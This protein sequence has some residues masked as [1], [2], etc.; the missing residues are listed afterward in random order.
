MTNIL[1]MRNTTSQAKFEKLSTLKQWVNT[2]TYALTLL[3]PSGEGQ[4]DPPKI[5][6]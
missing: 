5:F 4:V 3:I 6:P 2:M 1:Q